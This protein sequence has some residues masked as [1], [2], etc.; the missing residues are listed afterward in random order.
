VDVAVAS[1]LVAGLVAAGGVKELGE[2][3]GSGLVAGITRRV[4]KV[5]GPDTR[6][7]DA[8]EQARQAGTDEAAAEL[9]SALAWYA[10]Q[11]EAFAQE[12]AAWAEQ[13]GPGQVSQNVADHSVAAARDVSITASGGSIAAGVYHGNAPPPDPTGPGPA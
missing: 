6:S 5:F 11:D 8:L 3:A 7:V 12:L 1:E 13:A 2:A 9:A 4:R 10:R